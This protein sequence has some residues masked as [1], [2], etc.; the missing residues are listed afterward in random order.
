MAR[1]SSKA[2]AANEAV[3][4]HD[5]AKLTPGGWEVIWNF[6]HKNL[7]GGRRVF[8]DDVE[9]SKWAVEQ[10]GGTWQ[11]AYAYHFNKEEGLVE[12]VGTVAVS[13]RFLERKRRAAART[14]QDPGGKKREAAP[15]NIPL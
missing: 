1:S 7:T 5:R 2:P 8:K 11:N 13:Y 14:K 6:E 4:D 9:F 3:H 10:I 15:A 12:F